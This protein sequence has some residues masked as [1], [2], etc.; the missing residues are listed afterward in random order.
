MCLTFYYNGYTPDIS[1]LNAKLN[2]LIYDEANRET[3]LTSTGQTDL[4]TAADDPLGPE[5]YRQMVRL[6]SGIHK[7]VIEGVARIRGTVITIDD[8]EI[9]SCEET[10][11]MFDIPHQSHME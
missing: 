5:W 6:P 3:E 8:L 2:I 1:V 9:Q 11:R 7:V 10:Y 4:N